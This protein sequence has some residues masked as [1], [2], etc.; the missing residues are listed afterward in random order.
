MTRLL[1]GLFSEGLETL[2]QLVRH[3]GFTVELAKAIR[4]TEKGVDRAV[5]ALNREFFP[6]ETATATKPVVD[7]NKNPFE[8]S[9]EIQLAALRRANDEEG[10]GIPEEVFEQLTKTAPTWPIGR[11][12]FRSLRVRF[13]E[14]DEGVALTF[15]RH[16]KR[17]KAVFGKSW[18]WPNLRSAKQYLRLLVGNNTHHAVVEWI[19]IDLDT[20]RERDS[21]TAVRG[22]K[23]LADELFAFAWMFS[24]YI[25]SINY[26]DNPGLFAGGYEL[27]VPEHGGE[28]WQCV[29]YVYWYRDDSEVILDASWPSNGDSYYSVP[30]LEE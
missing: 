29:P 5:D 20:N 17:I 8:L 13:G 19:V 18:R 30:V 6:A 2:V 10:W 3:A 21:I 26:E 27:N 24:D 4:T 16:A 23:S 11:L 1:D 22:P 9:I 28:P 25:R 15:E 12:A 7:T 14:G